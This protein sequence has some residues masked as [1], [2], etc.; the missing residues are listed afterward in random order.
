M[1]SFSPKLKSTSIILLVV[2]L[3][4]FAAGFFLNKGITTEK[5]EH[6]MEA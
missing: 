5:I 3:V 6:M 4:L 1:Y 2:G